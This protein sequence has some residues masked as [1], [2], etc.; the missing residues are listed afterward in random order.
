MNI[1][2]V[3]RLE[4][5]GE[6]VLTTKQLTELFECSRQVATSAFHY[7]ED[8]FIADVDYFY[9][10]KGSLREFKSKYSG[11]NFCLPSGK[12]FCTPFSHMAST[13]YLWTLNGVEKLS[14]SIGTDKAKLIFSSLKFG[15]FQKS[16]QQELFPSELP[17]NSSTAPN[18]SVIFARVDRLIKLIELTADKNLR[19]ELIQTAADLL[20][21]IR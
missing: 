9:L 1:E 3:I 17:P 12:N 20:K 4:Y 19:D 11:K 8:T 6:K 21:Q 13:L 5:Q 16:A 18:N 15:Y 10:T 7:H 14:K 2:N